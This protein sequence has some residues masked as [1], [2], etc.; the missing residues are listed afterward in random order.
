M[1]FVIMWMLVF[2]CYP[3]R[4]LTTQENERIIII[5]QEG[6]SSLECCTGYQGCYCSNL[7]LALENIKNDTEIKLMSDISLEYVTQFGDI[8][9]V[10]ITGQDHTVQCNH[11][12][13]LVGKDII[14]IVMQGVIWDKCDGLTLYNFSSAYIINSLFQHSSKEKDTVLL[15]RDLI[16]I[17]NSTFLHNDM[18][19][20]YTL[21]QS[22]EV[23]NSYFLCTPLNIGNFYKINRYIPPDT[24]PDTVNVTIVRSTFNGTSSAFFNGDFF[25]SDNF[26]IQ[27][28]L[29]AFINNPNYAVM[30]QDCHLSLLDNV[31]FYNNSFSDPYYDLCSYGGGAICSFNSI[32]DL[33][34]SVYFLSNKANYGGA[35]CLCDSS[36]T[37]YQGFVAFHNNFAYTGG[38]AISM[39]D[40]YSNIS[41]NPAASLEFVNN[42]A[43]RGGV[44][45]VGLSQDQDV[46][47][48]VKKSAI[49]Y[50]YELLI[51]SA[52]SRNVA[53]EGGGNLAYF[54]FNFGDDCTPDVTLKNKN[55]FSSSLCSVAVIDAVVVANISDESSGIVFYWLNDL[56]FKTIAFDYF[57][58]FIGNITVSNM[59]VYCNDYYPPFEY[60]DKF[61]TFT[62]DSIYNYATLTS[63]NNKV[64]SCLSRSDKSTISLSIV[65]SDLP[66][67]VYSPIYG[68]PFSVAVQWRGQTKTC[69]DI[70]HINVSN[71]ICKTISC[72]VLQSGP[73]GTSFAPGFKC[74]EG[75]FLTVTPGYW[76]DDGL[77]YYVIS[78]PADYCAFY[79]WNSKILLEPFPDRDLQCEH[80]WKGFSCGVCDGFIKYDT[81]ECILSSDCFVNSVPYSLLALFM[82]SFFYWCVIISLIFILLHFNLNIT[83]GYAFGIIFYY[84]VLEQVVSV[85]NQVMQ[86]RMCA[87][88][89]DYYFY[90]CDLGTVNTYIL[91]FFSSIGNLKPPFLQYVKLC[92]GGTEVIDHKLLVYIH[93]LIVF[94]IVVTIFVS[95]RRFVCV[96]RFLGRYINSKSI[97]LLILLSYSSVSYTS[98]QLLRPLAFFEFK[99][100]SDDFMQPFQV[101]GE[102]NFVGWK[103]YWSPAIKYFH[104]HHRYCV[105]IAILCEIIIGFGFPFLLLFQ[106]YLTRHHNMN[107]MSIR[108]IID[109]L[110]ACYKNECYWFSAYY[111]ICR[112]VICG[113]DIACDILLGFWMLKEEYTYAK[114]I[115]LLIVC[116]IIMVMHMWF[117]PYRLKSLNV[118]D[119]L[120]LVSLVLLLIC[121]L[122]GNS[123]G[124]LPI[125]WILPLVFFINY[126]AYSTKAQHVVVLSSMCGLIIL[127][128]FLPQ[129]ILFQ[130]ITT[131]G[132]TWVLYMSVLTCLLVA[133]VLYMVI[134]I[135]FN[136]HNQE[137]PL[138]AADIQNDSDEDDSN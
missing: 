125:L 63:S 64:C 71:N 2:T 58:N 107:F 66:T 103:S 16:A 53:A 134:K 20:C 1:V 18:S 27:I 56:K 60:Q 32:V 49:L 74:V 91:K 43:L 102:S 44:L 52:R 37:V 22:I 97:S 133:Y 57:N 94:T 39:C 122:D 98:V 11:Q 25:G 116:C 8:S 111:L 55:L 54:N 92:L 72:N 35:I 108:P 21:A 128:I 119:G 131:L 24:A 110:Q 85:L 118:L 46:G 26:S 28:S 17:S 29:S 96:A 113:V 83:A 40:Y 121:G 138:L 10:T 6:S 137:I 48:P 88:Y 5:D 112:Q 69:D 87:I 109:Q 59:S 7:S 19:V 13:G 106:R 75:S 80:R 115:I 120:I 114:Y 126:L 77:H 23:Y 70:A 79:N 135:F 95:S 101:F 100:I 123:Y 127:L 136:R 81:T 89:E 78:C 4:V 84:S 132:I 31:T 104:D 50:Y 68:I 12:G 65:P 76:Y 73:N 86:D 41:V 62:A 90:S 105:I 33:I 130:G 36:F 67:D 61:F 117:Q 124:V 15:G 14:N 93:P 47:V 38:G 45:Y 129:V 34:G 51:N 9:N 3:T 82:I 30:L 42:S 99:V